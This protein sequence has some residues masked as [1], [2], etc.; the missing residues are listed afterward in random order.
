MRCSNVSLAWRVIDWLIVI[1]AAE[2]INEEV[3]TFGEFMEGVCLY[4]LF[5]T[6]DVLRRK[7]LTPHTHCFLR[8]N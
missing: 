3:L 7:Y 4:S 5:E 6:R 2:P 1:D 8:S